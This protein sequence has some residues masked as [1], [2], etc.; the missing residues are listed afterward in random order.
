MEVVKVTVYMIVRVAFHTM[1]MFVLLS[2]K[3]CVVNW[4]EYSTLWWGV[5][6][7]LL[8]YNYRTSSGGPMFEISC[9]A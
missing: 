3:H 9:Y 6:I 7:K 2:I 1:S 5:S 4:Q 8:E